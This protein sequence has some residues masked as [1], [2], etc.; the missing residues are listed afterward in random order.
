M[1]IFVKAKPLSRATKIEKVDDNHFIVWVKEPPFKGLANKA[2]I[3]II[4]DYFFV[5]ADEV[6][7][8]SGFTSSNKLIEI[9]K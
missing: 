4:S 5:Q 2:I 8:V 9:K 1:K 3:K 6:K 7:I